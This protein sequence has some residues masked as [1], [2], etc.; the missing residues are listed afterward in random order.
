[1]TA[2]LFHR[3]AAGP[4]GPAIPAG[5]G[6][7]PEFCHPLCLPQ[8]H[9]ALLRAGGRSGVAGIRDR[10]AVRDGSLCSLAAGGHSAD[11]AG[12]HPC[13][14]PQ[15][16]GDGVPAHRH[17]SAGARCGHLLQRLLLH[18]GRQRAGAGKRHLHLQDRRGAGRGHCPGAGHP[19]CH[20]NA[21]KTKTRPPG[22]R[23]RWLCGK[24]R[25][26]EPSAAAGP[27]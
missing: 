8:A 1:M 6:G 15:S 2:L 3:G 23:S 4:S 21:D 12:P 11:A 24:I 16:T 13:D 25:W 14:D 19:P 5:R 9:P 10:G 17:L 26:W 18:S 27:R 20:R 7:H 22:G